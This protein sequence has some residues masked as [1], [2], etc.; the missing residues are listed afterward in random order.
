MTS[1]PVVRVVDRPVVGVVVSGRS[2]AEEPRN[3]AGPPTST[4][5]R[6]PGSAPGLRPDAT[7]S[8]LHAAAVSVSGPPRHQPHR[9]GAGC[10]AGGPRDRPGHGAG[11]SP[12]PSSGGSTCCARPAARLAPH[13]TRPRRVRLHAAVGGCPPGLPDP[14][15]RGRRAAVLRPRQLGSAGAPSSPSRRGRSRRPSSAPLVG[16]DRPSPIGAALAVAAPVLASRLVAHLRARTRSSTGSP[17]RCA[18][19]PSPR[20]D[21][22]RTA[23]ADRQELHDVVGHEVTLIA[24][25]QAGAAAAALG[26][27]RIEPSSRWSDPD[28][29]PPHARGDARRPRRAV[30]RGQVRG[31]T[32]LTS[33]RR[34]GAAA[35]TGRIP[36]HPR[37]AR[38]TG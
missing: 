12:T 30:R 5:G 22:G 24:T 38:C 18:R 14:R 19:A 21:R 10:R 8:A 3:R 35:E 27:R 31:A 23:R 36:R 4:A 11:R 9:R 37:C 13:P 2:H 20:G 32:G 26:W 25:V 28:H 29:R 34:G 6:L 17:P 33:P 1:S 7:R 15:F 16:P